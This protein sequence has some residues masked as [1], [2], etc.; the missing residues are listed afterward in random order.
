MKLPIVFTGFIT[1][2]LMVGCSQK[3]EQTTSEPV[4]TVSTEPVIRGDLPITVTGYGTVEFD[5]NRQQTLTTQIEARVSEVLVQAGAPVEVGRPLLRLVPSSS[6]S[7]NLTQA[8]ADAAAA[9][10]ELQ[11]QKRLRADGLS[12]DGD[13]ERAQTAARDL[14]ARL[15]TLQDSLG[16]VSEVTAPRDAIIDAVLV[17]SGDVLAPGSQLIRLSEPDAIQARINLELEDA[18]RLKVG[19]TI[20]LS[21]L[22]GGSHQAN[23][24]I[25]AVDLRVNPA[26]RMTSV[27]SPIPAVHGFLP[28]EAVRATATAEIKQGVIL[29]PRAAIF[30]DEQGDYVFVDTGG[31]AERRR[32]NTGASNASQTEVLSGLTE[33]DQVVTQGGAILSDGMKLNIVTAHAPAAPQG[34]T[35]MAAQQ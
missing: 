33:G 25:S 18:T 27:V 14:T 15:R 2:A 35:E 10:A 34:P 29:V 20:R 6:S 23:T 3:T 13:V 4:A 19:G 5:P 17:S 7:L 12:S 8:R 32:I 16:V 22:D 31:S 24:K 28:G 30:T 26:T 9:N 11:R 1:L 21:G